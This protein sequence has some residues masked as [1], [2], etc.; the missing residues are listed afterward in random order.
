MIVKSYKVEYVEDSAVGGP[1]EGELTDIDLWK[2]FKKGSNAAF[3]KI[4]ENYFDSLYRFGTRITPNEELVKDAIHDVFLDLRKYG[5]TIGDTHH[6]KFYLFKCLKRRIIKELDKWV[7]RQSDLDEHTPFE[8]TISHEQV[9]ISSQLDQEQFRNIQSALDDL[10]PRKREAIYYL[11][12]E[13]MGYEEISEMMALSNPKSARDL[14]YKALR[15]LR[16]SLG[17]IPL[18]FQLANV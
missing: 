8:V 18:F 2:A 12:Y 13:G 15:S 17:F 7:G 16:N 9:L 6:I 10:S 3:L 4:Y 5:E 14:V 1:K 11:F